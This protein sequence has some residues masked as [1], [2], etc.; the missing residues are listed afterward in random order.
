M[1]TH[2]VDEKAYELLVKLKSVFLCSNT[3]GQIATDLMINPPS[4]EEGCQRETVERHQKELKENFDSLKLRAKIVSEQL[5]S[6]KNITCNEI[7]GAMYAFPRVHLGKG[8][9]EEAKRRNMHPDLFYTYL[10]KK[11]LII[12]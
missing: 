3:I 5:N 10:G 12:L 11:E 1:E 2:N 4:L 8:A 6:M 9:I 7:E